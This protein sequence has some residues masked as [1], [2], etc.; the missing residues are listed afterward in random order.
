MEATYPY[1]IKNQRKAR[2]APSRDLERSDQQCEVSTVP[3]AGSD[4]PAGLWLPPFVRVEAAEVRGRGRGQLLVLDL[5][6]HLETEWSTV[7]GRD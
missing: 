4:L 5:L 6:R 3:V 1:T 2:N 7:I